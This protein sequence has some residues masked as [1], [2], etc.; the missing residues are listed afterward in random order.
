MLAESFAGLSEFFCTQTNPAAISV[1]LEIPSTLEPLEDHLVWP[2]TQFS[3]AG[4]GGGL[5]MEI[6]NRALMKHQNEGVGFES[7][8]SYIGLSPEGWHRRVRHFPHAKFSLSK[9]S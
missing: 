1:Q 2:E 6:E 9:P 3:Y 8:C 5:Y 4:Q 7:R